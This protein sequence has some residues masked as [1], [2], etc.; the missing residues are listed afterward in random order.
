[1]LL[2]IHT[3]E[4]AFLPALPK[5][6]GQGAIKS[7]IFGG[8][9]G[10][11]VQ[12]TDGKATRAVLR[13]EFEGTQTLRAPAGQKIATVSSRGKQVSLS[14]TAGGATKVK[15]AAHKEYDVTFQ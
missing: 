1:M 15:L 7:R 3:G 11:H 6:W 10:V 8:A 2:E 9:I 14:T 12:W 13:P 5:A 4:I